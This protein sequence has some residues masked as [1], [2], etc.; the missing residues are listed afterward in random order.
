METPM[1]GF[2]AS[3]AIH[4]HFGKKGTVELGVSFSGMGYKTKE[5]S[6]V[7]EPAN[8]QFPTAT[9]SA[10]SYQY[11]SLAARYKYILGGKKLHY[12]ILPG[13]SID[14]LLQRKARVYSSFSDASSQNS[15]SATR[16]GFSSP[17]FS[18]VAAAGVQLNLSHRF[19]ICFE[20]TYK[21][22]LVSVVPD[23]DNHEYL[24]ALGLNTQLI[25]HLRK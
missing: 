5:T 24:Y 16:G 9:W 8:L 22:G 18:I 14:V 12:Y 13:F 19:A 10:F 15:I 1:Y 7:W 6:L 23:S 11:I 25:F 2:V 17:N 20:P 21:R 4:R 3:L